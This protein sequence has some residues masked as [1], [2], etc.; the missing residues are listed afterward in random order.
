M[1]DKVEKTNNNNEEMKQRKD[2]IMT[3]FNNLKPKKV[4]DKHSY[5]D[6]S[7]NESEE[8]DDLIV[9]D[10]SDDEEKEKPEKEIKVAKTLSEMLEFNPPK[11]WEKE[12]KKLI[13]IVKNI[14]K[15]SELQC[16]Y[17]PPKHL[18]FN[19]FYLCPLSEIKVVI[20][21]QDPYHGKGQ[22]MGLSFS[23]QR[24]VKVPPSLQNIYKRIQA[25]YPDFK[26]P[27]HGDLTEWVKQGVFLLNTCLTVAPNSPGSHGSIWMP[28][29]DKLIPM[30][31]NANKNVIFV[32]WGKQAGDIEDMLGNNIKRLISTHP[33]PHSAYRG[34]NK[35]EHPREI[36]EHLESVGLK[37]INWQI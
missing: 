31:T 35:C 26:I 4:N 12:I 11:G 9:V 27:T 2:K 14:E 30:I 24:G 33:S 22:A 7:D 37:P 5:F 23:V 32:L 21:G 25:L 6:I 15:K 20:I 10:D 19:L 28:F 8:D 3:L 34:F 16:E 36:N 13:P 1:V 18:V 17:Y 29:I